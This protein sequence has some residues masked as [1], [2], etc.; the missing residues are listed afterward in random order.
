VDIGHTTVSVDNKDSLLPFG[1]ID[2]PAQGATISGALYYNFGWVVTPK[3]ATIPV[4]GSTIWVFIDGV[5]VGHPVY[6]NYRVDIATLFPGLNNSN[7]AVGYYP[8]NTTLLTNGVH[9]IAWSV[10]DNDGHSAGIGS[11]YFTVQN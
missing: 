2:T 4:N 9:T 11:R 5:R 10:A 7:G 6:N 3:P 8:I 1:T